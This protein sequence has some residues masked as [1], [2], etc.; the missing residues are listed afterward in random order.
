MKLA[1]QVKERLRQAGFPL[2]DHPG[3]IIP[4]IPKNPR[5][6]NR[7]KRALLAADILPPFIHYLGGPADGY[8]RFVLASEHTAEQ[9][10]NLVAVFAAQASS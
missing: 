3:P 2:S 10:D 9:L 6:T 1:G 5:E 4:V 7:W 8:F